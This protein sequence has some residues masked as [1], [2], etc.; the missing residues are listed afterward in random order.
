[1]A[2]ELTIDDYPF[3]EGE[4]NFYSQNIITVA[5]IYET[6]QRYAKSHYQSN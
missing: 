2:K 4:W 3:E 5:S 1:M 6:K